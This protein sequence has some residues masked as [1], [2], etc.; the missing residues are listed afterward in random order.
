MDVIIA[1]AFKLIYHAINIYVWIVIIWVIMSW[2]VAFQVINTHNRFVA[3]IYDFLQRVTEPALAP[4]R[5]LIPNLGGVDISPVLL[6]L[7]LYFIQEVVWR[8]YIKIGV[9][10]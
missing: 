10:V 1:P 8:I 3:M 5:R 6:I 4:L 2:L 9:G 7:V